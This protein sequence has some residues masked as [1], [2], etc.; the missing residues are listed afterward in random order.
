ME[1]LKH[2]IQFVDLKRQYLAYKDEIDEAIQ[3]C[4]DNTAFIGG[5]AVQQF[6]DHFA[7]FCETN[8]C[9]PCGNGTDALEIGIQALGIGAGDEVI[10]PANSF[11]ASAEA[12]SNNQA[13]V[14][15]CDIH[16]ESYNIDP[17]RLEALIGPKTKAIMVV[18]LFGRVADMDP[19]MALA[20]KHQL[21]VIEDASQAH[22]AR[23]KGK[24]AGNFGDFGV[25]SFY[26]GKNLGAYGD[27]GAIVCNDEALYLKM[28][29]IANHG[30]VAKY[31]HDMIGRNSRLDGLQAVVL[32][33]KLPYLQSWCDRRY[34]IAQLYHRLLA[35]IPQVQRPVDGAA[36]R[37][38]YHLYVVRVDKEVRKPL[39]AFLK[40]RGIATGVHYPVSLPKLRA[41]AFLGAKEEDFPV[42]NQ[43][44]HEMLSLP[45]FA[46]LRDEEVHYVVSSIRTFFSNHSF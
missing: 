3:Q 15:F 33:V 7:A 23:Y 5:K 21:Y 11:V 4:L 34:E 29:K 13:E 9:V 38:V 43:Y 42:S 22:G 35:D 17:A 37:S 40:E 18:H 41:Y 19:I 2:K 1:Q 45:I 27:G 26:P 8:Y 16:P 39:Q 24:K 25:F 12:V 44:M 30:R 46:E 28:K 36:E 14:V 6:A 20:K 32:N 10:V 31:D